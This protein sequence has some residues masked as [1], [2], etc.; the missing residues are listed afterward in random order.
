MDFGKVEDISGIDFSLP[1]DHPATAARLAQSE[2]EGK[3]RLRLSVHAGCPIWQDDAMAKKLCP[4]RTPKSKRL[5][6]YARQFNSLELNSTGYGLIPGKAA[7]WAAEVPED[8]RFCPKVPMD[9]THVPNLDGVWRKFAAHC[10]SALAF[11]NKLG[12]FFLQFP[13]QFGPSRFAELERFLDA[14]TGTIPLALEVRHAGW[15]QDGAKHRFFDLLA[16]HGVTSIIDDTPGRR[17]ALH[18]RLTT[19]SAFIRFNGHAGDAVDFR[20]LDGWSLR[21]RKW[22]DQGLRDLY[23]YT[24]L[25][26]KDRTVELSAHFIAGLGK[27]TGLDLRQ[28]RLQGAEEEPSL[29]L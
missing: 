18:Q 10:E 21:I 5:A 26:P 16:A 23:F 22:M 28:P 9:V 27:A 15:F 6:C 25:D 24:H 13:E 11:G 7:Q 4:P 2:S 17:D 8:F 3:S 14:Q 19:S 20:R 1:P 12:L 29:A